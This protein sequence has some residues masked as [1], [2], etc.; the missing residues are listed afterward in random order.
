MAAA[1]VS[2]NVDMMRKPEPEL[3]TATEAI[4]RNNIMIQVVASEVSTVLI[5]V[6]RNQ[7]PEQDNNP[8]AVEIRNKAAALGISPTT[9]APSSQTITTNIFVIGS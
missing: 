9:V 2:D 5:G 7:V 6:R 8:S 4:G 1:E 3:N